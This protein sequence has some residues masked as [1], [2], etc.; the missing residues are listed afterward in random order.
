[1]AAELDKDVLTWGAASHA[2]WAIWGLVQAREDVE[3]GHTEPE[4]DYIGYAIGRMASF[5]SVMR[6]FNL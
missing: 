2:Q 3:A 1:M 6:S 5:R 4:F